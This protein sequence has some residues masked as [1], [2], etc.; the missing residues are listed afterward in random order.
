MSV[1]TVLWEMGIKSRELSLPSRVLARI[2][3]S[4]RG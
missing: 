3:G 2:M 1:Q 4:S